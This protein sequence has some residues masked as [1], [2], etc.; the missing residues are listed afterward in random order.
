DVRRTRDGR[1]GVVETD[2]LLVAT[3]RRPS[4]DQLDVAAAGIDTTA[5]GGV[6]GDRYHRVLGGGK[7]LEGIWALGDLSSAEQLKHVA[8]HEQ[9]IVRHNFLHPEQLRA[10]D[11]LPVPYGV[12]THRQVAWLAVD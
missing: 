4:S 11:T 9:R 12:F 3:G 10:S 5:D 1:E 8:K 6:V 7:V 2:E